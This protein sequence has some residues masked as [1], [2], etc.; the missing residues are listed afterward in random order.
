MG[1]QLLAAP[2]SNY[3]HSSHYKAKL[4]PSKVRTKSQIEYD[5]AQVQLPE[6]FVAEVFW[7]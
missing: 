1:C 2:S 3:I 5:Q 4:A 7:K 6:Q